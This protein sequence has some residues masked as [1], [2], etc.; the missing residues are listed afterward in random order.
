MSFTPVKPRPYGTPKAAVARLIEAAGGANAAME[1]LELSRT[2]VYAFT[3]PSDESEISFAR[4]CKLTE[5]SGGR[6]G[7]EHLAALAGGLFLPLDAA[8]GA[9]WHAMAGSASRRNARTI[10]TLLEALSPEDDTPGEITAQ[11]ARA[12]LELV[13]EQ[14]AVLAMARVKLMT[15]VDDAEEA[16]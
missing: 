3:D 13:D 14:L 12:L 2:R 9:D 16:E 11:E 15:I 6:P 10:S 5:T 7:A 4:V 8:E 1:I